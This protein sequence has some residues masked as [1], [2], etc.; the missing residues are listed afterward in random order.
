MGGGAGRG[1]CQFLPPRRLRRGSVARAR[2]RGAP[3]RAPGAARLRCCSTRRRRASRSLMVMP[4]P[5]TEVWYSTTA[6]RRPAI[7]SLK[8]SA[9]RR[10]SCAGRSRPPPRRRAATHPGAQ[11][12]DIRL[13]RHLGAHVADRRAHVAEHL[14][15]QAFGLGAHPIILP[16]SPFARQS[17]PWSCRLT[18]ARSHRANP[19]SAR[20]RA[21]RVQV[22]R[23]SA[24]CNK[25]VS[26]VRNASY[27][28]GFPRRPGRNP[29]DR[30][31]P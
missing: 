18:A 31:S 8:F 24:G 23:C 14:Q 10:S 29:A 3:Q 15:D 17:S 25:P 22:A 7:C 12:G 1:G 6:Q 2:W 9:R 28:R 19:R 21:G 5:M 30:P 27:R 13:G 11:V 20:R 26:R 16:A 4:C